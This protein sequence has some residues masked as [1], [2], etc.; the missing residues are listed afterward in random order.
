MVL[1]PVPGRKIAHC[2]SS[3]GLTPSGR[4][5]CA[6]SVTSSAT[7]TSD[8]RTPVSTSDQCSRASKASNFPVVSVA[9]IGSGKFKP[10]SSNDTKTKRILVKRK[11]ENRGKESVG[12]SSRG[13]SSENDGVSCSSPCNV[14]TESTKPT[15]NPNA[16]ESSSERS[17]NCENERKS[18]IHNTKSNQDDVQINEISSSSESRVV[19]CP[20]AESPTP[21]TVAKKRKLTRHNNSEELWTTQRPL[22]RRSLAPEVAKSEGNQVQSLETSTPVSS[23]ARKLRQKPVTTTS[24]TTV[25]IKESAKSRKQVSKP[26]SE[27]KSSSFL[28][29]TKTL[30]FLQVLP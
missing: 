11:L 8:C 20:V 25:L 15:K 29:K 5:V 12:T 6:S 24:A 10:S 7:A 13:N 19:R 26:T 4:G 18:G 16:S 28:I 17:T 3:N 23:K 1:A 22:T 2:A 9:K 14:V 30:M 27:V 21:D